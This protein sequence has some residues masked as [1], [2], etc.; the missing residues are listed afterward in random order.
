MENTYRDVNIVFANEVPLI[1]ESLGADIHDVHRF[2]NSLPNDTTNPDANPYRNMHTP[3][4]GVGGHCLPKDSWLL[5]Y[6][7]DTYEEI[8]VDPRII[9]ASRQLNDY[10]PQHM[11]TLL[12]DALAERKLKPEETNILILGFAFLEN[13][14]DPRNTPT[15]PLYN[16]LRDELNTVIIH[17]PYIKEYQDY[18]ITTDLAKALENKDAAILVT[19]HREYQHLTLDQLKATLRTPIIVDGRNVW[20]RHQAIEKGFTFIFFLVTFKRVY[21]PSID[22]EG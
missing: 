10:M 12:L 16:I 17:D 22:G 1:C 13:S 4:A 6:G 18:P 11:K 21:T 20:N 15:M 8:P 9:V 5:K 19:K 2:V 7:L 14:D 3:G